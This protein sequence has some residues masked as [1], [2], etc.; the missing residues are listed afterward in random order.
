MNSPCSTL[1][2]TKT[3][4]FALRRNFSLPEP[5]NLTPAGPLP[6]RPFGIRHV[7]ISNPLADQHRPCTER[8][9]YP[10]FPRHNVPGR[11]V[12][13]ACSHRKPDMC[14][15]TI[16]EPGRC[17]KKSSVRRQ[18][19]KAWKSTGGRELEKVLVAAHQMSYGL[20]QAFQGEFKHGKNVGNYSDSPCHG[21][22][23]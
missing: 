5:G 21:P 23:A 20:V 22:E 11:G 4:F 9:R 12:K 8:G 7:T 17:S 18:A 10:H 15:V 1:A 3:I 6:E 16:K 13:A 2:T 14:S 19:P